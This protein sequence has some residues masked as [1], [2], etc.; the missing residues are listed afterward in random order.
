[1]HRRNFKSMHGVKRLIEREKYLK[2][3]KMEGG[4]ETPVLGDL[5]PPK[6]SIHLTDLSEKYLWSFY[7]KSTHLSMELGGNDANQAKANPDSNRGN[8]MT[9]KGFAIASPQWARKQ[10]ML[11]NQVVNF[12]IWLWW[13]IDMSWF[14][15]ESG[16]F[17]LFYIYLYFVWRIMFACLMVCRW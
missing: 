17:R 2:M 12:L 15:F 9:T 4:L 14:E 6:N 10:L 16:I 11:R 3:G 13:V 8:N 1:M 5:N 7:S